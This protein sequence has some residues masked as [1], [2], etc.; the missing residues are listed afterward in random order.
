M[1]SRLA[2]LFLRCLAVISIAAILCSCSANG[3]LIYYTLQNEK[4]TQD[5]SM[6]N[7]VTIFD[8][9]KYPATAGGNYYA[10]AGAVWK[11]PVSSIAWDIAN[12]IAPPRPGAMCNALVLFSN[13]LCG[14]FFL[15]G[16]SA[17][18]SSNLGLF[19]SKGDPATF[20]GQ[21][22]KL[23]Q[24]VTLLT[25]VTVGT[26]EHLLVATAE[27]ANPGENYYYCLYDTTD[28]STFTPI[29]QNGTAPGPARTPITGI[30]HTS[31]GG[32][33][34]WAT[35]AETSTLQSTLFVWDINASTLSVSPPSF[36]SESLR[37][38][39]SDDQ[40][41][42]LFIST[43]QGRVYYSSNAGTTWTGSTQ[44]IVSTNVVKL[45]G[46][47]GSS[48]SAMLVGSELYGYY[49]M[50][51][52]GTP[53]PVLNR[54]SPSTISLYGAV[55]RKLVIDGPRVFACTSGNGLW[56]GETFHPADGSVDTWYQE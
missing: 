32:E 42:N 4:K 21:Q 17:N 14:G 18:G 31:S 47:S 35:T 24:Q 38:I 28:L 55:V 6:P 53:A 5:S 13:S 27:Q 50:T 20:A 30:A 34:Y 29:I 40:A 22:A 15:P 1:K 43:G 37:H 48:A 10:A 54:A 3:S 45:D 41:Q 8:V 56:R 44:Q 52:G 11:S 26:T 49:I 25:V 39:Y 7:D 36:S 51:L 23:S 2:S 12:P 46:I 16:D 9:V 19:Q 33:K